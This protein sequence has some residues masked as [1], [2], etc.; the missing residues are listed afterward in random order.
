MKYTE[1]YDKLEN[2]RIYVFNIDDILKLFPSN[3][4]IIKQQIFYWKK[5]GW[6]KILKKGLYE[7]V[8]PKRRILSDMFIANKLY[9]PSYVSLETALSYYSIIP[10]VAMG[11]TSVTTKPTREF[12]NHYGFF[13]YRCIVKRA[14]LGYRLMEDQGQMVKIAE[15]EKALVDYIY[16]NILDRNVIDLD[17]LRVNKRKLKELDKKKITVYAS[18]FSKRM[19]NKFRDIY[20][21]I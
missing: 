16:F 18:N 6:I 3:R 14:Y 4:D 1:L 21:N 20:A 10:E 11:V 9:D 13:R 12:R 5:Q 2:S 19:V 7:I 8:Y 17:A 15:P